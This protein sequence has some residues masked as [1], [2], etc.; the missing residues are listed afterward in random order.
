MSLSPPRQVVIEHRRQGVAGV[1]GERRRQ[2]AAG[3]V[4]ERCRQ[5]E[6]GIVV[7]RLREGAASVVVRE[8]RASRRERAAS[9]LSRG[10]G[11]RLVVREC[12]K[13]KASKDYLN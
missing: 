3:V 1:V 11:K 5:R 8:R 13:L 4:V 6:A 2:G 10:S 7:K 9:I 12:P